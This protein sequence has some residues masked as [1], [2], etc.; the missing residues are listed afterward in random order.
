LP[1]DKA[2]FA[3]SYVVPREATPSS[4]FGA[5]DQAVRSAVL[6]SL[7]PTQ[8]DDQAVRDQ[9]KTDF[10]EEKFDTISAVLYTQRQPFLAYLFGQALW[11]LGGTGALISLYSVAAC[12]VRWRIMRDPLAELSNRKRL[13]WGV[14]IA[15]FGLYLLAAV[16][17]D[18]APDV[19]DTLLAAVQSQIRSG[20]GAL[21][22]AGTAYAT[23]SVPLAALVTFTVNFFLGSLALLTLPSCVIPGSGALVAAGRAFLWGILLAPTSRVLASGM[24]PHSGTLLLEGEGYILATFFGLLIRSDVGSSLLARYRH[25]FVLNLKGNLVVALVLIVAAVY[26]AIEVIIQMK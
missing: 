9:L 10:P 16:L 6:I 13:L 26:E 17:I 1:R 3:G 18:Q 11:C 20:S 4:I 25:A 23:K 5:A 2:L 14:H 22:I 21:G 12:R 7:T 24:L 19:Q 8:L 15:Y